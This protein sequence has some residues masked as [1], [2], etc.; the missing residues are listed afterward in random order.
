MLPQGDNYEAIERA[1]RWRIPPRYNIAAD[2][3]DRWADGSGRLALLHLRAHGG[4]ERISFDELR[5]RSNRLANTL[6]AHGIV[7]GDRIAVLLPQVPEAAVAHFAAYKLGAIAVPLF[8]LFGEQALE[9]RLR[10]SGA[11]ALVTDAVGLSKLDAIR[12]GLPALRLVC[13]VDGPGQGGAGPCGRDG[14]CQ[15]CLHAGGYGG[16]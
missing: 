3:C 2:A 14:T 8:Q 6:R 16:G 12:A 13:T 15:R 1:F 10:D 7:R 11:A 4:L 5:A 9:F